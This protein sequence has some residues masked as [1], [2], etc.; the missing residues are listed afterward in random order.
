M[1]ITEQ[2]G[3]ILAIFVFAP[4]LIYCGYIYNNIFLLLFG[5]IF[6]IYELFWIICYKPKM[7]D[8]DYVIGI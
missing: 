6:L 3:R 5:I 4:Y 1:I 7:I 8:T 2:P